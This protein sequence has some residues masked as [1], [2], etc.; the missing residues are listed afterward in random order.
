[1]GLQMKSFLLINIM[2]KSDVQHIYLRSQF[3]EWLY[4]DMC[5][6]N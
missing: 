4:E 5:F 6:I 1:M 2:V 3:D